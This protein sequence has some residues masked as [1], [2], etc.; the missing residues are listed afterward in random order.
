MA[1]DPARGGAVALWTQH[2]VA[3]A[4]SSTSRV[5]WYEIDPATHAPFT[6]QTGSLG[7]PNLYY[8]NSA[9][10][11]DRRHNGTA[12]AFGSNMVLEFNASSGSTPLKIEYVGKL[13]AS[14]V[15]GPVVVK[16]SDGS[17]TDSTSC[18]APFPQA[19][20]TLRERRKATNRYGRLIPVL[21]CAGRDD[22][23]WCGAR[24]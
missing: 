20:K 2:T 16:T 19:D 24:G 8:F 5:H 23:E 14:P 17:E 9:I 10:A 13:G 12:A 15:S 4:S 22:T 18:Q 21:L 7:D 3:D 1:P 6:G 11:P